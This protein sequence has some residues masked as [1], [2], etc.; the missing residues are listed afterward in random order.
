M[1]A[2]RKRTPDTV[3]RRLRVELS[4]NR[5]QWQTLQA[6]HELGSTFISDFVGGRNRDPA[7]R[8]VWRLASHFGMVK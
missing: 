7:F 6:K 2:I 3:L 5:G 8:K 4:R 1:A